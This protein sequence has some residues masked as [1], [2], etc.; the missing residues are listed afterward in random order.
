MI[1]LSSILKAVIVK[2]KVEFNCKVYADDVKRN[3]TTPC[4][5][6]K[7]LITAGQYTKNT[8]QKQVNIILTY[9]PKENQKDN[10]HYAGLLDRVCFLFAQG[11][12]VD[13]RH[14]KINEISVGRAGEEDDIYQIYMDTEFFDG[15]EVDCDEKNRELMGDLSIEI[16]IEGE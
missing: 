15:L 6:I 10:L 5:F 3:Y 1:K 8:M 7:P 14:L 9:F 16:S 13:A 11:L 4:F 2:L 12:K